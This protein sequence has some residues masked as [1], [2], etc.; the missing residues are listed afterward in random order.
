MKNIY[1]VLR[2]KEA[3]VERLKKELQALR[4]VAPLLEEELTAEVTPP[5]V[6][7]YPTVQ[8]KPPAVAAATD[9]KPIWP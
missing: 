8:A 1:E 5:P 4:V 6:R 7:T 9:T 2:Q 3:E